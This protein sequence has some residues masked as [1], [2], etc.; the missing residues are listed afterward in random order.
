MATKKTT[1]K[2]TTTRKP[3]APRKAKPTAKMLAAKPATNN[4]SAI[5]AASKILSE[6]EE[7]LTAK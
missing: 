5:N 1:T 3:A 7:P 6:A 2:E 4:M